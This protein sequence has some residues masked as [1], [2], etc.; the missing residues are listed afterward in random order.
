[1]NGLD[2]EIICCN[3]FQFSTFNKNIFS[4]E[5]N[6]TELMFVESEGLLIKII[7]LCRNYYLIHILYIIL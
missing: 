7:I 4:E 3:L 2:N 5:N 6:K 1:M